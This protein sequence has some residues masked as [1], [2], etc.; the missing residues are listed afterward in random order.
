M[1]LD[2]KRYLELIEARINNPA[3]LQKALKNR[4]RRSVA[5]KDGKIDVVGGRSHGARNHR[6][7][8]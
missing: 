6:S 8:K 7:R 5:G 3:S 2:R 4:A 1:T